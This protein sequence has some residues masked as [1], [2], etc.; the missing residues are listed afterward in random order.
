M[1][2]IRRKVWP[3]LDTILHI[4]NVVVVDDSNIDEL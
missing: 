3:V 4:L 1:T 2:R